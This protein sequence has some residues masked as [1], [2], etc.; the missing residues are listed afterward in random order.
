MGEKEMSAVATDSGHDKIQVEITR[1]VV[2]AKKKKSLEVRRSK[3][4]EHRVQD[5]SSKWRR[6]SLR[7]MTED[8]RS[9][10]SMKEEEWPVG[11]QITAT[12]RG[13]D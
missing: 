5:G 1:W 7:I 13:G 6:K 9:F 10:V 11:W 2:K 3:N 12:W 8:G 4:K